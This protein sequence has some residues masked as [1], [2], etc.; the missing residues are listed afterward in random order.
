MVVASTF[1][2]SLGSLVEILCPMIDFDE[3]RYCPGRRLLRVTGFEV[4][5]ETRSS[6][7][8]HF[9]RTLTTYYFCHRTT[10]TVPLERTILSLSR[11]DLIFVFTP[12]CSLKVSTRGHLAVDC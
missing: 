10:C 1:K 7:S 9:L 4:W 6:F 8:A 2:V 3:D 5:R 11:Q 12:I